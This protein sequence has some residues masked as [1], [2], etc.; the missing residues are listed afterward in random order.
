MKVNACAIKRRIATSWV[1]VL[2]EE[3]GSVAIKFPDGEVNSEKCKSHIP[4]Y[5]G[6]ISR[7]NKARG[8]TPLKIAY[9][10][11]NHHDF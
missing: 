6:K 1:L 7:S 11:S 5:R 8:M 4:Y 3:H 2:N 9:E 10:I